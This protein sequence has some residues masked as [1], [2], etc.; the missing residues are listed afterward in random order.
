MILFFAAAIA[1]TAWDI[2]CWSSRGSGKSRGFNI[3]LS[4][5]LGV[6]LIVLVLHWL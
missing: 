6:V 4:L 2:W 3:I 1:R 5:I